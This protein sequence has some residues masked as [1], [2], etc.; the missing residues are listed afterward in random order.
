MRNI[1]N[2]IYN[3]I[4]GDIQKELKTKPRVLVAVCGGSCTR[5]TSLVSA[6]L[7]D[8]FKDN[9]IL[10][11]QDQF[12]LQPSYIKNIDSEYKWDHPNNFGIN[13]CYD[14][15]IK[16]KNNHAVKVPNYNFEKEKPITFKTI[17][18]APVI[19][20]EGLYTNYKELQGLNDISV[21]VKSPWY[22]RM[23]R[24]ALR[25]T[26]DRY[27]G[28]EVASI[29]ESFC[30]TVTKAH[31]NFV[32]LQE[33][34]SGF[35][36][37]TPLQFPNII[38]YYNLRPSNFKVSKNKPF[39]QLDCKDQISFKI[40]EVSSNQFKF[41]FFHENKLYLKFDISFDLANTLKNTDWLAY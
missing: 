18:P 16:L 34:L 23:I 17:V 14:A 41:L 25:N 2:N 22:T 15:L 21:Y 33:A 27:K 28:R 20:F 39:F 36:L 29:V 4:I 1:N 30:D 9:A 19:I 26:L 32:K 7:L 35:V 37:E 31:I 11:S 40:N 10:I 12:Q 8:Y 24:R 5:K 13:A 3:L 6:S 38:A